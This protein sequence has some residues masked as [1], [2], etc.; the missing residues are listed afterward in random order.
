MKV[1]DACAAPP[2]AVSGITCAHAADADKALV[3]IDYTDSVAPAEMQAY[4]AGIKAWVRCP[5]EHRVTFNEYAA[6]HVTGRDTCRISF[7]RQPVTWAQRG[8][9]DDKSA[10]CKATFNTQVDP[11]LKSES[12]T[13]VVEEPEMS[14]PPACA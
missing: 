14:H 13:A 1:L 6:N 12:G 3:A 4:V 5:R 10:P 2:L 8:E 9:L 7:E 11:H